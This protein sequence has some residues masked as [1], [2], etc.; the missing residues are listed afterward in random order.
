[1]NKERR[2]K[3]DDLIEILEGLA[4]DIETLR[5]EEQEYFDNMPEGLKGAEKGEAAEQAISEMEDAMQSLG[6]AKEQ[7]ESAKGE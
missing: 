4:N 1:M 6:E 5:D 3:L 7:L 2:K